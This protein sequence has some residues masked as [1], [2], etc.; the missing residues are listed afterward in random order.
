MRTVLVLL[1]TIGAAADAAAQRRTIA[2]DDQFRLQDVGNPEISPD[3]EWVLYT[4]AT[5][6]VAADR[7]NTDLW[8]V[9]WDGSSRSQLTFSPENETSPKWSPDGKYISFLSSRPGPAK[10]TQVWLLD[11]SGGE[12]R[13]LTQLKGGVTSYDWSPD[14]KR[15]A[16]VRRHGGD[17]APESRDERPGASPPARSRSSSTGYQFK[18]DGQTYLSG[19]ARNRIS[20]FDVA[21]KKEELLTSDSNASGPF[22]ESSPAWS[23]DGSH[24]A[25]VSN[26]D[27]NWDRT[28]NSDVFV[29]EA[30][31][32]S[33]S[34]RAD[35]VRRDGRRRRRRPHMESGWDAHRLRSGQ[36]AEVQLPQPEP[37]GR[38][39]GVKG[40]APRL[41]TES[42]DRSVSGRVLQR[43]R[44]EPLLHRCRRSHGLSGESA[45]P[46]AARSSAWSAASASSASRRCAKGRIVVDV[47]YIDGTARSSMPSRVRRCAS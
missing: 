22:D 12:A 19:N 27:D 30:R 7:R 39:S 42:L 26:H 24:I 8:K 17:D 29:V 23:P 14:G 2:I 31:P 36:R 37:A 28:R 10:G 41:L 9:R 25:F 1:L 45:R 13:Q 16:L 3:G 35:D 43:R 47:G 21:T 11:R 33:M 18:R 34:R 46:L 32:G 5:T 20:L 38:G 4:V 15:L 40:G 44:Q 6:D